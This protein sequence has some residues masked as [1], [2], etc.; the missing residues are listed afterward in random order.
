VST[1]NVGGAVMG[2]TPKDS[3]L[4]KYLQ[5]WDAHNVFVPGG[6]AFPQ[7][8][9]SNPTGMIGALTYYSAKAITEQYIKSPGPLV[10]A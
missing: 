6:N 5:S 3:S 9:Q 2:D 4:N 7:N 10:A 1:H 8:F